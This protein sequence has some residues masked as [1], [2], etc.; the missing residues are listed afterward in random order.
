MYG[1]KKLHYQ[2]NV[3]NKHKELTKHTFCHEVL[4][5]N[6][7]YK[8]QKTKQINIHTQPHKKDFLKKMRS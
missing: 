6:D 7:L 4:Y 5:C 2:S 8:S 3:I 1:V